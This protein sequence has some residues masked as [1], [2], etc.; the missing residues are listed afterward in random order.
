MSRKKKKEKK[1]PEISFIETLIRDLKRVGLWT[2][3][4]FAVMFLLAFLVDTLL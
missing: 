4:S 1:Q 3:I 2:G